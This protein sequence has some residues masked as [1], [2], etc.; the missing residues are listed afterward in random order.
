[1]GLLFIAMAV[2]IL[3]GADHQLETVLVDWSPSWLT[4]F[5]TRF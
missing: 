2:A 5:T 1:M 4:A 3:T